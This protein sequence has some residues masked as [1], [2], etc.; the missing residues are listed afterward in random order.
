MFAVAFHFVYR[1]SPYEIGG[2]QG[3]PLGIMALFTAFNPFSVIM[4]IVRGY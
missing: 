4:D 2:Y 3:G 1:V